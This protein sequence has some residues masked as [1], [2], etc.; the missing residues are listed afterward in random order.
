M[1]VEVMAHRGCEVTRAGRGGN[2]LSALIDKF[3]RADR[4]RLY[5]LL[6]SASWSA[7]RSRRCVGSPGT[8]AEPSGSV[9]RYSRVRRS[10]NTGCVRERRVQELMRSERRQS[11]GCTPDVQETCQEACPGMK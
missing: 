6:Q 1:L 2:C 3:V 8:T 4:E 5:G 7:C 9:A 10:A 11:A